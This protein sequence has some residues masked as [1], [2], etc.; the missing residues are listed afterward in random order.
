V[1]RWVEPV[2]APPIFPRT[3]DYVICLKVK[4][5]VAGSS[6]IISVRDVIDVAFVF[7]PELLQHFWTDVTGM[8]RVYFTRSP[9]TLPLSVSVVESYPCH[10]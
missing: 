1:V 3:F 5:L 9:S 4:E 2:D 10:I 6:T 7:T 8:T